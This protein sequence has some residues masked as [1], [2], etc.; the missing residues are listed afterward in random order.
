MKEKCKSREIEIMY[1]LN[2]AMVADILTKHLF[3]IKF[4][5]NQEALGVRS[6]R[7]ALRAIQSVEICA[8]V[9]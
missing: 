1:C 8:L 4:E 2:D 3:R 5:E 9:P 6:I 7:Y